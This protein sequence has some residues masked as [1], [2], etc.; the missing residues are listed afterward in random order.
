VEVAAAQCP[1]LSTTT[2]PTVSNSGFGA[3]VFDA[4]VSWSSCVG[5]S[6]LIA[7]RFFVEC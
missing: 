1:W 7:A 3:C 2:H 4:R 6:E 5:S